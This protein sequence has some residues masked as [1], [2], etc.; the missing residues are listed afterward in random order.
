MTGK[1]LET[2]PIGRPAEWRKDEVLKKVYRLC[3]GRYVKVK[4]FPPYLYKL[5]NRHCGSVRAAK[6]E[7]KVILGKSW[8]YDKFMKCVYQF[9]Q[10]RYREDRHWPEK[11][12]ALAK[13]F[14]G[15]VRA[16]KWESGV[17]KDN[18]EKVRDHYKLDGLWTKKEFIEQFKAFC[19]YGYKKS[20]QVP[21]YI[22]FFA[23][24]HFGSVRAAKWAVG[25]LKDPRKIRRK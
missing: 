9:A 16:A 5:C 24:K 21:G 8:T 2:P 19:T 13:R 1:K 10:P 15:S 11:L 18:R 23:V 22:R 12:R 3:K 17:I 4:D 14:C 7:A 6:W 25:I 20:S